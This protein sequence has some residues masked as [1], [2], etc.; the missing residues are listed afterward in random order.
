MIQGTLKRLKDWL[1]RL[2]EGVVA[3]LMGAL[4]IDVLWQVTSRYVFRNPSG[5]TDELATLMVIWLALLGASA[6]FGRRAH[7]GVDFLTDKLTPSHRRVA[8]VLVYR[9]VADW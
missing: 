5:W 8:E 3:V 6:A 2:L 1:V 7:L 9:E 4:V